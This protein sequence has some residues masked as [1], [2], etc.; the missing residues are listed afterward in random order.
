VRLV[1]LERVDR[2]NIPRLCN[3]W[4][5]ISL[6]NRRRLNKAGIGSLR[7]LHKQGWSFGRGRLAISTTLIFPAEPDHNLACFVI[8]QGQSLK[9]GVGKRWFLVCEVILFGLITIYIKEYLRFAEVTTLWLDNIIS[10]EEF[11]IWK[12]KRRIKLAERTNDWLGSLCNG[13]PCL[14]QMPRMDYSQF[15]HRKRWVDYLLAGLSTDKRGSTPASPITAAAAS[16]D[17]G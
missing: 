2:P 8:P 9:I 16:Q 13:A 10:N 5:D 17:M 14:R 3:T 11:Q 7:A 4:W 6:P 12:W 15:V 1:R